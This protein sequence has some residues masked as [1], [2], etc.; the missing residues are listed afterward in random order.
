MLQI[1]K[2]GKLIEIYKLF[3]NQF[4]KSASHKLLA[5]VWDWMLPCYRF[6]ES[7]HMNEHNE[8]STGQGR[9][10]DA[11]SVGCCLMFSRKV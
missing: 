10:R 5:I 3:L 1:E 8:I 11:S 7:E 4:E 6:R 9:F 2:N